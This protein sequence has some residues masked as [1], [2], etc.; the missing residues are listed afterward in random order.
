MTPLTVTR[1]GGEHLRWSVPPTCA[2]AQ[3]ASFALGVPST[4]RTPDA[5]GYPC[6]SRGRVLLGA[7]CWCTPTDYATRALVAPLRDSISCRFV[8]CA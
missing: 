2:Y 7:V 4:E 1:F 8:R 6:P 5:K 3:R